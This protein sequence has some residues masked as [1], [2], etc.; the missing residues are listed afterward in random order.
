MDFC[1]NVFNRRQFQIRPQNLPYCFRQR[2]QCEHYGFSFTRLVFK[3]DFSYLGNFVHQRLEVD[4][5]VHFDV[6][7][8]WLIVHQVVVSVSEVFCM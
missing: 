3:A 1:T 4:F 2:V 8:N 6:H 5:A 7:S